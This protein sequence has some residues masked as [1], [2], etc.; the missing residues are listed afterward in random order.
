MGDSGTGTLNITGGGTVAATGVSIYNSQSL[1]AI[2]VG[3]GS[4]LTVTGGTIT[5]N[6]TVRILAGARP[7]AGA[8]FT[9][10]SAATWSGSGTYQTIGG[11][12]NASSHV[13]TVSDVVAGAAGT[14]VAIDPSKEQRVLITDAGAGTSVGASFLATTSPSTIGLTALP[15][16][17][18]ALSS[19]A[20]R[21]SGGESVLSGWTFLTANYTSGD[22]V[23]L[24]LSIGGGYSHDDFDVWGYNG[25]AWTALAAN[26]LA[27]DGSFA[28]FTAYAL[29]GY[30]YAV[31]GVAI[32]PGDANGDGKVDVND[33]TIVLTN[34]GKTG[35]SWSRGDFNNDGKVDIND[36][37]SLLANYG[38]S[39]DRLPPGWPPCRNRQSW[40]SSP[41]RRGPVESWLARQKP[42]A[43]GVAHASWPTLFPVALAVVFCEVQNVSAQAHYVLLD[44]G[45]LGE[46][47][48]YPYAINGTGGIAGWCYTLPND[49]AHAFFVRRRHDARSGHPGGNPQTQDSFAYG[50]NN[51]GQ[52][53]G[54]SW[55]SS[56]NT[57][58]FLDSSGTMQDLA[59]LG[60]TS[61]GATAVNDGGKVVGSSTTTGGNYPPSHAFLYSGGTMQDLGTLGGPYRAANAS[62][63]AGRSSAGLRIAITMGAMPSSTAAERCTTS[64]H[65]AAA[66][67]LP[68]TESTT[69]ARSSARPIST[70]ATSNM[71]FFIAAG[72]CRT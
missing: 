31:T 52:I 63:I 7:A 21:L 61:A 34:Y 6:A 30:S 25:N 72:Q 54:A 46:S 55:D 5:N 64:E 27:F 2:D 20:S 16:S 68:L 58:A 69:A 67:T 3:N 18:T 29:N 26:D 14:P 48:V 45:G 9:P 47:G 44:L 32:L 39:S 71:R 35:M 15:T 38:Q 28:S 70:P 17:S 22:P 10:I 53:V 50:I 60:G 24:S 59:T 1:L 51:S 57:R 41:R 8:T 19:L 4:R 62:T 43:Q 37:S 40:F 49:Y 13:F 33:L 66:H 36:L 23:Y 12:W 65:S 42:F 56:G 11:T